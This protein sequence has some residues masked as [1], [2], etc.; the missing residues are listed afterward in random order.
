MGW[1]PLAARDEPRG[2]GCQ[3]RLSEVGVAK[4]V[5]TGAAR[6]DLRL[7]AATDNNTQDDAYADRLQ[8]IATEMGCD[9]ERL[10]PDRED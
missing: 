8:V 2:G 10:R 5:G 9:L 6:D 7:M 1:V 3:C 4:F